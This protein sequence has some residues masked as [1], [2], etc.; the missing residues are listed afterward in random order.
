MLNL[1]ITCL[2]TQC[3]IMILVIMLLNNKTLIPITIPYRGRQKQSS[4]RHFLE[5]FG[6]VALDII[7]VSVK[8]SVGEGVMV[9]I[10]G[11]TVL[12]VHV[13]KVVGGKLAAVGCIVIF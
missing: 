1:L 11:V 9:V 12:V 4:A 7:V 3:V 13:Q 6:E 8:I 5:G 10:V 2:W